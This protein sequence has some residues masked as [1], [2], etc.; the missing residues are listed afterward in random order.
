MD[1]IRANGIWAGRAVTRCIDGSKGGF[2][3]VKGLRKKGC[4][5]GRDGRGVGDAVARGDWR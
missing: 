2:R 5:L 4:S 3:C 1:R